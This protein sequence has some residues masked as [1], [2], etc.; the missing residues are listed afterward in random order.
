MIK[1]HIAAIFLAFTAIFSTVSALDN[2]LGLTPQMGWN[3]WNKFACDVNED[4][5]K[6]TADAIISLGL[7]K[8]GYVYVNIDDCWSSGRDANNTLIPDP[9]TFP[10]GIKALADYVHSLGLKLG[11]YSD[12]GTNTCAGRPGS[13][14]YEE[15]DAQTWADWGV[16][17]LKYDNCN[18][19]GIS[20]KQRYPTMRDALNKTGRPIF[21]SLCEWGQEDPS[22]WAQ[23]VGNSWRTT[24]D[25]SANWGSVK[26]I[27]E[28]QV[29]LSFI[30]LLCAQISQLTRSQLSIAKDLVAGMTLTC[31]K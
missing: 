23:T 6:Q 3:S 17:Y 24:G 26:E 20:P 4:V 14:N 30:N 8:L 25:I 31:L 18:N 5:I 15:I 28:A 21:Y 27:Y 7:D 2:G 12:A 9:K 11:I 22:S 13:L 16:D 19:Q 1:S 29:N 10:N